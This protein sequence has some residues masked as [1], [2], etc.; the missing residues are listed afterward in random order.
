MYEDG[1]VIGSLLSEIT[2]SSILSYIK[3]LTGMDSSYIYELM[4]NLRGYNMYTDIDL[5][6]LRI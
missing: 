5:L 3:D 2:L 4:Y 1:D 6:I